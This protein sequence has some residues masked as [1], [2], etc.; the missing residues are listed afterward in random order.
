MKAKG[1]TNNK[2]KGKMPHK[3]PGGHMMPDDDMPMYE[4]DKK[5]KP[6]KSK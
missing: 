5:R 6:K 4:E 2:G 3:M 1:K